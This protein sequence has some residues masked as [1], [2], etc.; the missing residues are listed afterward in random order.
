M[1]PGVVRAVSGG[2]EGP[3][4]QQYSARLYGNMAVAA[5]MDRR[6]RATFARSAAFDN[7]STPPV[8]AL[9]CVTLFSTSS[10]EIAAPLWNSVSS[11]ANTDSSD[12]GAKPAAPSGGASSG[13]FFVTQRMSQKLVTKATKRSKLIAN[14]DNLENFD[15]NPVQTRRN[16]ISSS[17]PQV[18]SSTQ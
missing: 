5:S 10:N 11:D 14:F 4:P 17:S 3:P 13:Q 1:R 7:V 15:D 16:H 8:P 18:H 2:A 9:R 6:N 12:D